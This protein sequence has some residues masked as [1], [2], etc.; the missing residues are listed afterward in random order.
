MVIGSIVSQTSDRF[1]PETLVR[2]LKRETGARVTQREKATDM[3]RRA[4]IP[5]AAVVAAPLLFGAAGCS[6]TAAC[7]GQCGPPFQLQ[8]TFNVAAGKQAASVIMRNCAN[9][10]VERIGPVRRVSNYSEVVPARLV[11]TI[12]T[13]SMTRRSENRELIR[14]LLR[15]AA[16]IS[17]DY[18]D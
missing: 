15:S 8:V 10:L 12:Y 3:R 2:V 16:V 7:R 14:C 13:K 11:A 5:L 4:A 9:S 6:Q 17:A 18:P 1:L